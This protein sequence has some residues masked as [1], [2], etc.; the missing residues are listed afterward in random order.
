MVFRGMCN[1]LLAPDL[2][3]GLPLGRIAS[4]DIL[5]KFSRCVHSSNNIKVIQA[6]HFVFRSRLSVYTKASLK[7]G[8]TRPARKSRVARR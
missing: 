2:R 7:S 6:S 5:K 1:C 8:S 4:D 3:A